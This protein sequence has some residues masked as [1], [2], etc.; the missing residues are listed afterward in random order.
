MPNNQF[1]VAPIS[2]CYING[3]LIRDFDMGNYESLYVAL[4]ERKT[5]LHDNSFVWVL[6]FYQVS[7]DLGWHRDLYGPLQ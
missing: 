1:Y 2:E 6:V 3:C 4:P 5:M 7:T